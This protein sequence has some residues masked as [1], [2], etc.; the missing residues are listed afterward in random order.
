M[1]PRSQFTR[2]AHGK[3]GRSRGSTCALALW[4][5]LVHARTLLDPITQ[6][7]CAFYEDHSIFAD[8]T[9]S[10]M[11]S[12]GDRIAQ[13]LGPR[14]AVILQNHGILTVG[15]TVDEAA[16]FFISMERTCQ[17]QMIAETAANPSR[18]RMRAPSL[19]RSKW[20]TP[21]GL[22]PV[23]AAMG[24]DRPRAARFLGLIHGKFFN[25]AIA[26]CWPCRRKSATSCR[27]RPFRQLATGAVFSNTASFCSRVMGL[28][29]RARLRACSRLAMDWQPVIVTVTG[30]LMA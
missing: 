9:A 30:T 26:G 29:F 21:R 24:L 15:S 23:S 8:Y 4:Q 7:A 6:D 17:S 3:A 22:V 1:S 10:S 5:D 19:P 13:A 20:A 16:W 11:T 28:K 12:E 27:L 2:G 25:P 14:K 18:S